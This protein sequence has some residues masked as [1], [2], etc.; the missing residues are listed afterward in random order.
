MDGREKFDGEAG[1]ETGCR[2][3]RHVLSRSPGFMAWRASSV[4]SGKPSQVSYG[5]DLAIGFGENPTGQVLPFCSHT[6]LK[7]RRMGA[8]TT[9][10]R[11]TK[12]RL[13]WKRRAIGRARRAES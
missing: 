9:Y 4:S 10:Q 7:N 5:F 3:L 11:R 6:T 2:R 8:I 1:R 13:S 12:N